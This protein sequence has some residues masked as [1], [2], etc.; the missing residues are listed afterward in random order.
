VSSGGL[1]LGRPEVLA[2]GYVLAEAPRVDA[3]GNVF[4]TDALGGGV[5]RWSPTEGVDVAAV[6]ERRG[7]GGLALHRDG[8]FVVSGR[9][10]T[11][12]APDGTARVVFDRPEGVI[13]FNDIC[14]LPTGALLAGALRYRP[15]AGDPPVPGEFWHVDANGV[16][17]GAGDASIDVPDIEWANG[18]GAS[19]DPPRT[20]A[21]DYSSGRIWMRDPDGLHL[22]ATTPNGEV[23]GLA[24]DDEGCVWVALASDG[25]IARYQLDGTLDAVLDVEGV[26]FVTSLAFDGDTLYVTTTQ[27]GQLLRAAAPIPGPRH[28]ETTL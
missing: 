1:A 13:G 15:F 27:P 7:A 18:C 24:L 8:G 26:D 9:D 28:F 16:G 3:D 12:V 10:L 17:A 19:V 20:Y 4:F 22:F 25:R 5:H 11:H 2:D 6:P 21:C 14:A 23:D